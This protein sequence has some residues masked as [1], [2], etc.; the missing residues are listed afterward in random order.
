V[1]RDTPR[2]KPGPKGRIRNPAPVR[3]SNGELRG[4]WLDGQDVDNAERALRTYFVRERAKLW[5]RPDDPPDAAVNRIVV[6]VKDVLAEGAAPWWS[7]RGHV[8]IDRPMPASPRSD[9][10][11]TYR[12]I[13]PKP[14]PRPARDCLWVD[15]WRAPALAKRW[16][17][18]AREWRIRSALPRGVSPE[19]FIALSQPMPEPQTHWRMKPRF[20]DWVGLMVAAQ[21]GRAGRSGRPAYLACATLADLLDATPE[22]IADFLGNYRRSER[23]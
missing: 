23:R 7:G 20:Y 8:T 13:G 15:T 4:E 19:D 14:P 21:M 3:D 11:W 6:L 22:K 2:R 10:R 1:S 16:D 9:R 18:R 12:Y 17:R 5:P